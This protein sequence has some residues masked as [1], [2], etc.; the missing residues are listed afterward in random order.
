VVILSLA[1]VAG[2]LAYGA[3]NWHAAITAAAAVTALLL[4]VVA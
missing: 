3:G 1:G 4:A 2:W